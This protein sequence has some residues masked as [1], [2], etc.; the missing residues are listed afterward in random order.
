MRDDI[1]AGV[2]ALAE[3]VHLQIKYPGQFPVDPDNASFLPANMPPNLVKGQDAEDVGELMSALWPLVDAIV[4]LPF[5]LPTAVAY[6]GIVVL[7]LSSLRT[8]DE[9]A[10]VAPLRFPYVPGLLSF[11]ESPSV[12]EAWAKLKTEPDAVM[13][14]SMALSLMLS[15]P[16]SP[17]SNAK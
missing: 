6:A 14:R 16:L 3:I 2:V 9:V 8:V 15:S 17:A 11:R 13:N 5:A 1:V 7:E 12:L 4:D 10:V